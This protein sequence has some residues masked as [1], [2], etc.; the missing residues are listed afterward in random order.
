MGGAEKKKSKTLKLGRSS[1]T[2][3][4][5]RGGKSTRDEQDHTLYQAKIMDKVA[6]KVTSSVRNSTP[7]DKK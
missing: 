6:K 3:Y 4:R 5:G 7:S 1:E 2:L